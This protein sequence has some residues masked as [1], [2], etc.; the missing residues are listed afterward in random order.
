VPKYKVSRLRDAF[1][2]YKEKNPAWRI[3]LAEGVGVDDEEIIKIHPIEAVYLLMK[4]KATLDGNMKRAI[5]IQSIVDEWS[6]KDENFMF[7]LATYLDLKERGFPVKIVDSENISFE[8]FDRGANVMVDS[9]KRY[10]MVVPAEKSISIEQLSNALDY[11]KNRGKDLVLAIIDQDGDIVYYK[12]DSVLRFEISLKL[13][14][15]GP[16]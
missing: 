2:I 14:K 13:R 16:M 7:K 11:A 5:D 1:V 9:S 15:Y 3:L 8:V 6:T 4:G 10:I 12:V